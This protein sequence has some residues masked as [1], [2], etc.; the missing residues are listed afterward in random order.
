M[1]ILARMDVRD[2][3]PDDV[4]AIAAL[5]HAGWWDAH[6]GIVPPTLLPH[7]SAAAFAARAA[8]DG[9]RMRVA[10]PPG[11]PAGLHLVTGDELGQLYL[12]P[13][14]RG[15]GLAI[16]LVRDAEA[17]IA[18]AGHARAWLICARGNDRAAAFY[19]KAGWQE[20]GPV[21]GRVEAGGGRIDLSCIRFERMT[22]PDG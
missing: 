22:G 11:A 20:V 6:A 9:P 15:T 21:I 1:P 19:R 16:R 4:P 2:A 12:A 18:A 14:A 5:W 10:G 7:R 17:R 3:A 8:R 13:A